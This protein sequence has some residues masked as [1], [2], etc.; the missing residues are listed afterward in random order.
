MNILA[1]ESVDSPIV[2]RLREDGHHVEY[3]A[4]LSPS[5][6]DEMVLEQANSHQ[7]LLMTADKD[8]G[9]LVF[10]LQR[11]SHGVILVR[12]SGLSPSLK[13]QLVCDAVSTHGKEMAHAFTVISTG[14]LRI[15]RRR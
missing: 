5:I 2:M 15:R 8:F 3:V 7:A 13:A 1:D 10:R 11:A 4:E 12:L 6:T 9:E 14:V